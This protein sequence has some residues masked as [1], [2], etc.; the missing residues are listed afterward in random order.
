VRL[1]LEAEAA[2]IGTEALHGR[3]SAID[4]ATAGRLHPNDLRRVVR[5]LEVFELTG[6][7]ISDYQRQGWWRSRDARPDAGFDTDGVPRC[8][9]VDVPRSEL[10]VRI[11]KRVEAMFA[12][13]W[14]EEVRRLRTLPLPLSK[15]ASQALGYRELSEYLDG[16]RNFD[17][18]LS[19]IQTRTR[20]FAKRQLTWFRHLPEC[21]PCEGKLTLGHWAGKMGKSGLTESKTVQ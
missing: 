18:T 1:R 14:V 19:V 4:P 6:K 20:Q 12:A 2:Q 7:P 10:Y 5:A 15:E 8:L 9:V 21:L 3:L 16:A 11:N 17:D 13:G